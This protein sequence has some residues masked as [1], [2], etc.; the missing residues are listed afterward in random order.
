[1]IGKAAN[2]LSI[3]KS[4]YYLT[5][6]GISIS[7]S[8]RELAQRIKDPKMAE[9]LSVL[10]D[11]I[12]SEGYTF[13]DALE[14]SEL[15]TRYIPI[16]KIGE[17]TG[18]MLETMKSIISISEEIEKIKKKVKSSL[19]Y[20]IGVTVLSF[21]ISFAIVGVNKKVLQGLDFPAVRDTFP[22]KAGW[23]IVNHK[24]LIFLTYG[25]MLATVFFLMAKNIHRMPVVKDLYNL[26]SLGQAFKMISLCL[27]SR[28]SPP[29]SFA[30][31]SQTVGGSWGNVFETI[32]EELKNRSMI[33]VIE[34]MEPYMP[35]ENYIVLRAK[36]RSGDTGDGFNAVGGDF[37]T[38][39]IQKMEALSPFITMITFLVVAG[40]I[41]LFMSP[42]WALVITFMQKASTGI[43]GI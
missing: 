31:A 36:I 11:L 22:Y 5:A 33:D 1:M 42:T 13:S 20:P 38:T 2:E 3:L 39:S 40:Q 29:D 8:A 18:N 21:I 26:I 23:F 41:V 25:V 43:G 9:K 17:K 37:L 7:E 16:I 15:F 28:M 34:E 30:F 19:Y 35:A 12:T 14:Q 24:Y 27:S 32:S 10:S 6:S 4:L